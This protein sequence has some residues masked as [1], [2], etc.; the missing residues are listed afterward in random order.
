MKVINSDNVISN[1]YIFYNR[2]TR[3]QL[4]VKAIKLDEHGSFEKIIAK[5]HNVTFESTPE[6]FVYTNLILEV[7]G[8][9]TAVCGDLIYLQVPKKPIQE[10]TLEFGWHTNISNQ[11]I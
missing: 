4:D 5:S 3:E 6:D 8:L 7:P 9:G 2:K 10:Y 11:K 1:K